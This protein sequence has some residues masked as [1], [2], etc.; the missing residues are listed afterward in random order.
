MKFVRRLGC[1]GKQCHMERDIRDYSAWASM[2]MKCTENTN[3]Q[4]G[5]ISGH[6]CT[7]HFKDGSPL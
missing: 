4:L 7:F 2:E 1:P 5:S 6:G 3:L